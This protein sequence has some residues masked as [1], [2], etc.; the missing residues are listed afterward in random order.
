[1]F[2]NVVQFKQKIAFVF[3]MHWKLVVYGITQIHIITVTYW[4]LSNSIANALE[5]LQSCTKPQY[6]F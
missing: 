3:L 4:W 1:M 6:E 2:N 5:L